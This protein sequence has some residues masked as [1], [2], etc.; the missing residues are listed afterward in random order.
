MF[1]SA[2][3]SDEGQKQMPFRVVREGEY[4]VLKGARRRVLDVKLV[5]ADRDPMLL[6]WP[7]LGHGRRETGVRSHTSRMPWCGG[8][9]RMGARRL[10]PTEVTRKRRESVRDI[11]GFQHGLG[12]FW[13]RGY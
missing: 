8:C 9:L 13:L 4:G 2:K 10:G 1:D 7:K 6:A 11:L 3:D 12:E 5:E